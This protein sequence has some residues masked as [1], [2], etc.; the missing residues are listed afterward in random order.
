MSD[1]NIDTDEHGREWSS[2][3]SWE[4]IDDLIESPAEDA[5]FEAFDE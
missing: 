1:L 5:V 4:S 2:S 3:T